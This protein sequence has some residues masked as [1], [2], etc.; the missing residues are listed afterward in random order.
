[1]LPLCRRSCRLLFAA[2]DDSHE[3]QQ[4]SN[5][6][7][8]HRL[9]TICSHDLYKRNPTP[10]DLAVL[11]FRTTSLYIGGQYLSPATTILF[12]SC[13][14]GVMNVIFIGLVGYKLW[15]T[16]TEKQKIEFSEAL[17]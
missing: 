5:K 15:K 8:F 2:T 4:N 9:D 16:E 13:V 17:K 6:Y 11:A 12:F 1:M 10:T 3:R 7:A 14:G